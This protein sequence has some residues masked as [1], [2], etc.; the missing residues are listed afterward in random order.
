MAAS[1]RFRRPLMGHHVQVQGR[2]EVPQVTATPRHRRWWFRAL[3]L[4]GASLVVV[5][6]LFAVTRVVGG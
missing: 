3:E 2:P 1:G 4:Y 6:N 5:F